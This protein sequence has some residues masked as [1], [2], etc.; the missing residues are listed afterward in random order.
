MIIIDDFIKDHSLLNEIKKD[1]TF[2][3]KNGEYMWW[4]GPWLSA[5]STLKQK[6][7]E[8]IWLKNSP[9]D[10]TRYNPIILEGFEYWTGQ[11]GE[12]GVAPK[13][14]LHVDKDEHLWETEKVVSSPL[15]GSVFYPLQMDIDGGYLEIQSKPGDL[16]ERIE[17]KFNR[18]IIFEA[19]NFPHQVTEVTRGTRSA[20]AINLWAS[21]PIGLAEGKFILE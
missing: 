17:A 5:A 14:Q 8:E 20:I 16:L 10:F 19:G 9:W 2:F 21:A 3:S 6:L 18:L 1:K 12:K 4:G 15:I 7:I 13:L 11:Y